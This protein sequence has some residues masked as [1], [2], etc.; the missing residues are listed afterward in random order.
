MAGFPLNWQHG[1]HT[2]NRPERSTTWG[3]QVSI[4]AGETVQ[5]VRYAGPACPLQWQVQV[6]PQTSTAQFAV[7]VV[8]GIGRGSFTDTRSQCRHFVSGTVYAEAAVLNVTNNSGAALKVSAFLVPSQAVQPNP[9]SVALF[10]TA[11]AA[12]TTTIAAKSR[13]FALVTATG[14]ALAVSLTAAGQ[15]A[16]TVAAN[17]TVRIDNWQGVLV[18][19]C[20]AGVTGQVTEAF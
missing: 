3:N 5:L 13:V 1:D 7:S 9:A 12:S 2:V 16:Y 10:S 19:V 8:A 14:G 4:A 18:I 6:D 17:A 15:P 20:P 11:A